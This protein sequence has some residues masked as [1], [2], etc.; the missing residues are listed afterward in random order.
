[1]KNIVEI[2][3]FHKDTTKYLTHV[4]DNMESIYIENWIM[5][6]L[7]HIYSVST[8]KY[9]EKCTGDV[10][11]SPCVI[12]FVLNQIV[13]DLAVATENLRLGMFK[14]YCFC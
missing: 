8:Q 7:L 4:A 14:S 6:C 5:I 11:C 9:P 12:D 1:V 10:W 3:L 13:K 2:K